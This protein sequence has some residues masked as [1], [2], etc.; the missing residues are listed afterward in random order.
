MIKK[1]MVSVLVAASLPSIASVNYSNCNH[2]L[3]T[4]RI[5]KNG[6]IQ[7]REGLEKITKQTETKDGT[8]VTFEGTDPRFP[9]KETVLF[10]KDAQGRLAGYTQDLQYSKLSK[11]EK[12][13]IKYNEAYLLANGNYPGQCAAVSFGSDSR[14][15]S[16][17][18]GDCSGVYVFDEKGNRVMLDYDTVTKKNFNAKKMGMSWELFSELK[19][20]YKKNQDVK[21]R[22][23]EAYMGFM[24][25]KGWL[26]PTGEKATFK[27]DESKC[28][29]EKIDTLLVNGVNNS[30]S[31]SNKYDANKCDSIMP[32]LNK[33][34]NELM[35]CA[36]KEKD[37]VREILGIPQGEIFI[38]T[39]EQVQFDTDFPQNNRDIIRK[40]Y[41][42]CQVYGSMDISSR[43]SSQN[44]GGA[45]KE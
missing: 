40:M 25:D 6:E 32:K 20:A 34:Q 19:S 33:A 38:S 39:D 22:L 23:A 36:M 1:F 41:T 2:G 3:A 15:T 11:K 42:N 29:V 18:R 14:E 21:K 12:N 5:A 24:D 43:S 27:V 35:S 17:H 4:G 45:K 26:F 30:I 16:H 8:Q 7:P 10:N 44:P 31:E 13:Q 28:S 37:I 9:Y